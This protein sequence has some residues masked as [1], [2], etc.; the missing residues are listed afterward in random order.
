M[1]LAKQ[2]AQL[3]APEAQSNRSAA[4]SVASSSVQILQETMDAVGATQASNERSF[5]ELCKALQLSATSDEV[6]FQ[7]ARCVA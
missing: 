6:L 5:L 7:I 3:A 1:V 2:L 4:E